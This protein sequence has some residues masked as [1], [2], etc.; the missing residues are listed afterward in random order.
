M[1]GRA[2][3]IVALSRAVTKE[4]VSLAFAS[5]R[6][7]R[8]AE[9]SDRSLIHDAAHRKARELA[10]QRFERVFDEWVRL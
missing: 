3:N 6:V 8:L 9:Q 7:F 5:Y 2:G 1:T 10:E 4:D